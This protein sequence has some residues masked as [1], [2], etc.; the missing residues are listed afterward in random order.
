MQD[1]PEVKCSDENG[2]Y[3]LCYKF[4]MG[5]CERGANCSFVH[6]PPENLEEDVVDE[7]LPPLEKMVSKHENSQK[8]KS[9]KRKRTT[10]T[11]L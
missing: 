2:K 1:L 9:K 4:L 3:G 5:R 8:K 11:M 7:M 10:V 6:L